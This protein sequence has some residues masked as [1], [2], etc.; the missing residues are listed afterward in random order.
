VTEEYDWPERRQYPRL[1]MHAGVF[2]VQG[3]RGYLTEMKDVSAGG[4]RVIRPNNWHYEAQYQCQIFCI[5]EQERILCLHGFVN[6]EE[7]QS[8]GFEFCPGFAV[9]A[10]Q[11]LAESRNWR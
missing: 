6:H 2:I 9:Q 11:L 1:Q 10:E 4:L 8:L 3:D 5:L 7:E